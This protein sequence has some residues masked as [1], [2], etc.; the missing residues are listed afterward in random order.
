VQGARLAFLICFAHASAHASTPDVFGLGSGESAVSGASAARVHDFSAG[1]YDPAGLTLVEKPE[2]SLGVVGFGSQ[3]SLGS[4]KRQSISDP[5]AVLVG[6]A[7]PVPLLRQLENR[8]YIGLALSIMPNAVVRVIAHRP[9]ESFYPLYDNR[10]QRLVV[11]PS[12][13]V[14]LPKGVSLGLGFNYLAGLGGRV[15]GA[16]GVTRAIEAR[17][18]EAIFS[19]L[20]VNAGIRWQVKP[21]LAL[22][23]VYREQF[24]IP[25][26]TLSRNQ[27]AGQ[28]INID[29]DADG[30]F[31]PHQL[32]VGGA[33]QLP[34]RLLL[35]LD[36]GWSHWSGWRGPY[37]T[38]S[39]QLPLVGPINAQPPSVP[40][41]DSGWF[42]AGLEWT[43]LDKA[44][45][46]LLLRGGYGF[47]SAALPKAPA[48]TN[49][50]D[51]H[52][53]RIALGLGGRLSVGS[54]L[55]RLDAHGQLDVVGSGGVAWGGGAMLTVG[56]R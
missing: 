53:H 24:S 4:G 31:T 2:V 47:E 10:T 33:L 35:S 14:R 45:M 18:D 17:V 12:V 11:L 55:L 23:L 56:A 54:V 29:V 15:A 7:A 26:T 41:S 52:K 39:S 30:L 20:S 28:P 46:Q 8:I 51:G 27:V 16:E 22:A 50:L 1:Y 34:R 5:V 25:F 43:A 40:F 9:S 42:R 6:G 36:A 32:L 49:L 21:R 48:G 19:V 38:V 44:K 37:V 13:A 3:L